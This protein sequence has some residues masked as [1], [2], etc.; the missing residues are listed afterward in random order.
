MSCRRRLGWGMRPAGLMVRF[1][2]ECTAERGRMT[3]WPAFICSAIS[4][5]TNF[6]SVCMDG[7]QPYAMALL[8]LGGV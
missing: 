2:R 5:Q 1:G 7:W 4:W 3:M 6:V 8:M